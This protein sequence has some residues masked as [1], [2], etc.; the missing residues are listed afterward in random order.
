[1]FE[2]LERWSKL[3]LFLVLAL[4]SFVF[5][6]AVSY[7]ITSDISK[8]LINVAPNNHYN[9]EGNS[10][11]TFH[12]FIYEMICFVLGRLGL[13]LFILTAIAAIVAIAES[14][15]LL[16]NA[17]SP[18]CRLWA[19]KAIDKFTFALVMVG[20]F[21]LLTLEK[22]DQTLK[23]QQRAWLGPLPVVEPQEYRSPETI[24]AKNDDED[25]TIKFS[26][27][28]MGKE[29]ATNT[30]EILSVDII[31]VEDFR[32]D[33]ALKAKIWEMLDNRNCESFDPEPEGRAIF[34]G[35]PRGDTIDIKAGKA[36]KAIGNSTHY[37]LVAG[38]LVYRTVNDTHRTKFCSIL[39]PP[40]RSNNNLWQNVYCKTHNDA[41]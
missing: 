22:T 3:R 19:L 6:D 8:C 28:N 20:G 36:K 1:M 16:C 4:S 39:V 35:L 17:R 25:I 27:A 21:Q 31:A 38:C 33:A 12:I 26:F 2:T 5:L 23:L 30:N 32:R 29:P 15:A 34:P 40:H 37:T 13:S 18:V 7:W 10:C 24:T 11:P 14:I 41:D 9:D